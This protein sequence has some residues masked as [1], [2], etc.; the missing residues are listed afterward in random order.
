MLEHLHSETGSGAIAISV[1]KRHPF[2]VAEVRLTLGATATDLGDM[3]V[4]IDSRMGSAYDHEL[5]APDTNEDLATVTSWRYADPVP[6]IIFP[7]DALK[8]TWPNTGNKS[9]AVEILGE[10]A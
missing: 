9:W 7:G 5:A 2:K 6:T 4:S 1:T 10:S 8:V 3:S